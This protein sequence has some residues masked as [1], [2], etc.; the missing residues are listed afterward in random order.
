MAN[1]T[2]ID[3]TSG[4][5]LAGKYAIAGVGETA[6]TRSGGQHH[7]RHVATEAISKAMTDAGLTADDVDGMP[8]PTATR[9]RHLHRRRSRYPPQLLW[10]STV[11]ARRPKP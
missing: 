1:T 8:T 3:A 7:P 6:Y 2:D 11:A 10:T 4:K 5:H 9:P